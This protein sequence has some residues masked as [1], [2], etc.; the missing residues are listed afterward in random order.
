MLSSILRPPIQVDKLCAHFYHIYNGQSY[1]PWLYRSGH[2]HDRS[3]SR[4]T[5]GD[6]H[7][8]SGRPDRWSRSCQRPATWIWSHGAQGS[9]F[10]KEKPCHETLC[11]AIKKQLI[12]FVYMYI[13]SV[14]NPLII[15]L[16][17]KLNQVLRGFIYLIITS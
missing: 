16:S 2:N 9:R 15:R 7:S 11:T 10:L 12:F 4:H 6:S 14:N 1:H 13:F 5:Q 8:P 3:K 17:M